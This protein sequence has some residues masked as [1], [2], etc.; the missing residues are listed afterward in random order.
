MTYDIAVVGA[1]MVGALLVNALAKLDYSVIWLDQGDIAAQPLS[2]DDELLTMIP[3]VSALTKQSENI[4]RNLNVWDLIERQCAYSKMDVWDG[5]G[6]GQIDFDVDLLNSIDSNI[7]HII[8]N[9]A[10]LNALIQNTRKQ[11]NLTILPFVDIETLT[12]SHI[13]LKTGESIQANLIVGADGA[14]SLVRKA[15]KVEVKKDPYGHDA[16]VTTIKTTQSHQ[17]TCYQNFQPDGPIAFL[18]LHDEHYCS[19]VWSTDFEKVDKL[20]KMNDADFIKQLSYQLNGSHNGTDKRAKL[21]KIEAVGKRLSFELIERKTDEYVKE[22]F[23]L[24]GD[25]AHT[26]HPLAGQGANLGFLDVAALFDT[27]EYAQARQLDIK[28]EQTLR[29]FQRARKTHNLAMATSMKLIQ[30]S[31]SINEPAFK[32]LRNKAINLLQQ[33]DFIKVK[34]LEAAMGKIGVKYGL[35]E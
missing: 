31:F 25:A 12:Q 34:M 29:R 4:L 2:N 22:G 33:Q 32:W 6:T 16:L 1:G 19:I 7:G 10:I 28:N 23:V 17:N 5:E 3:R 26:I 18:P 30:T 8:E 21:G 15:M 14:Q 20:K 11:R 9:Q 13:Q 24:I 27:L 35:S